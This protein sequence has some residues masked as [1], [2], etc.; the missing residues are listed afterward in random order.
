MHMH[1]Y[2]DTVS[3]EQAGAP[4]GGPWQIYPNMSGG[5][6]SSPMML[7]GVADRPAGA[8]QMCVLVANPNHSV[9]Q[10]T[11]NCYPLP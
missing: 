11:G 1:F 2:F 9:N 10:G 5:S 6:A 7:Y 8:N 4:G 3:S